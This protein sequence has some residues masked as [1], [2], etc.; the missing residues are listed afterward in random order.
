MTCQ[1]LRKTSNIVSFGY[2]T[3]KVEKVRQT[4]LALVDKTR[5]IATMTRL[6]SRI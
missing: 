2:Y 1:I 4:D 5:S 3:F 6:D